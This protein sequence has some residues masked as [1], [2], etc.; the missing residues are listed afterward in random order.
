MKHISP[1]LVSAAAL[2]VAL[3]FSPA[4]AE[5]QHDGMPAAAPSA[6]SGDQ[7]SGDMSPSGGAAHNPESASQNSSQM[8]QG[9]AGK[10]AKNAANEQG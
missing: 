5:P 4:S 2:L 9:N 10:G 1:A 8:D 3:S 6:G 7:G